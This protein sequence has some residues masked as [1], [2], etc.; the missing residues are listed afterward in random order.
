MLCFLTRLI[1]LTLTKHLHNLVRQH[2]ANYNPIDHLQV[3]PFVCD[4]GHLEYLLN[5]TRTGRNALTHSRIILPCTCGP[6]RNS[7][8][9]VDKLSRTAPVLSFLPLRFHADPG[10]S[11]HWTRARPDADADSDSQ[12]GWVDCVSILIKPRDVQEQV[13]E[14][15]YYLLA[16]VVPCRAE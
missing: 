3:S 14:P 8:L 16:H 10:P 2:G 5:H 13:G 7:S 6:Y 1:R 4:V 11:A 9:W 12:D 15:F